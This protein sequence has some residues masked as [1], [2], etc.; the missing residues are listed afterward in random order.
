MGQN[1]EQID[2]IG[3]RPVVAALIGVPDIV[4]PAVVVRPVEASGM[5]R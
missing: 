5:P 1:E 2:I 4:F 3:E